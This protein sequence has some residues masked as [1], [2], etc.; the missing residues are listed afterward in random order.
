MATRQRASGDRGL[1]LRSAKSRR[2]SRRRG[3]ASP[4]N[5][6]L[7]VLALLCCLTLGRA[8]RATEVR[9]VAVVVGANLAPPGR[10]RLRYAHDDARRVVEVLLTV[11]GFN[12]RDVAQL[13]DP[14]PEQLLT[15]LD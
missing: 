15:T 5:R 6:L 4:L 1:A 8:A 7:C 9:R 12:A 2:A 13:L 10:V 3:A 14:S 11:G